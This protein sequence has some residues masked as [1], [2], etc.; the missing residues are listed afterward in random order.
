MKKIILYSLIA[1][2]LSSCL[3]QNM[4]VPQS[5]LLPALERKSG[6][7]AYVGLDGNMYV[8][9][10][11]GGNS[12]KL[13]NDAQ[14]PKNQGDPV[15]YYQ[16]PTW[17][18]D[19]NQ[20][21]FMGVNV[22][23]TQVASTIMVTNIENDS[24]QEVYA[25][26][27]ELP[28]YLYWSPD[29]KNISFISSTSAGGQDILLQS[30]P[31]TGGERT[32]IDTGSPYYWSWAPN[33]RVMIV[34]TG[35]T[36][37]TSPDH[38]AFLRMDTNVLE[39]GLADTPASFQ[40][41]AWSPDGSH[42][43]FA[44]ISDNKKQ[45]VLTDSNGGNP[46]TIGTFTTKI[47]FAWSRDGSKLGY[48]DGIQPSSSG[49]LGSLHIYDLATSKETVIN[50]NIGAFFWSPSGNKIAY[51]LIVQLAG[52]DSGSTG[53]TTPQF[54]VQLNVLDVTTGTSRN[55][56]TYIPTQQFMN[57]LPY[58]DQYHQSVTIWSPDDNNLVLSFMDSKG[59]PAI[60]VVAASGQL[61]PRL[62]AAGYI[63]FWSWK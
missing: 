63:A 34:H 9:N 51:F 59:N 27:S 15:H 37:S 55:L 4:R 6:L 5:P 57:I 53:S 7:I 16:F 45:I 12:R 29:N 23:N 42:I 36:G 46:T 26:Q 3:P 22:Q 38:L 8:V 21:A 32:L 50:E 33:G 61:E 31:A 1:L 56:F 10:Q 48:L 35:G 24:T 13:T 14:L 25:N 43:A 18:Q 17:A 19:G 49:T 11:G 20:L 62:L 30:V 58:F 60:A 2:V 47:A 28:I 41:P 52:T 54:G 44:V 40:A 39:D